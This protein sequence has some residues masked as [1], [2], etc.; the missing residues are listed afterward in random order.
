VAWAE[1]AFQRGCSCCWAGCARE[2]AAGAVGVTARPPRPRNTRAATPRTKTPMAPG[3]S[4]RCGIKPTS[5]P[6]S[7]GVYVN[8]FRLVSPKKKQNKSPRRSWPSTDLSM[9]SRA[10]VSRTLSSDRGHAAHADRGRLR[11]RLHVLQRMRHAMSESGAATDC[12]DCP[13]RSTGAI[14]Q[15][16]ATC[17][18]SAPDRPDRLC[19]SRRSTSSHGCKRA[20]EICHVVSP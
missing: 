12:R 3:D 8:S 4:T 6:Q 7:N 20:S 16:R 19:F 13:A 9:S 17:R 2:A 18:G 1:L 15:Q 14:I 11:A 10:L 5:S